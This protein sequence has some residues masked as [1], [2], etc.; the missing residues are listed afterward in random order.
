MREGHGPAHRTHCGLVLDGHRRRKAVS[1]RRQ[2]SSGAGLTIASPTL[3]DDPHLP[4]ETAAFA[5]LISEIGKFKDERTT[6]FKASTAKY[7]SGRADPANPQ[8]E[9]TPTPKRT[10]DRPTAEARLALTG[11]DEEAHLRKPVEFAR[12]RPLGVAHGPEALALD[13]GGD[14]APIGE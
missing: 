11:E 7:Q 14:V 2:Q 4:T 6:L 9:Q 1:A 3:R 5:M 12:Q 8:A 10:R 13:V